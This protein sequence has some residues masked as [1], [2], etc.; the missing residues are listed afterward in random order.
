MLIITTPDNQPDDFRL[1]A[2]NMSTY[3]ICGHSD[4]EGYETVD[5]I[6]RGFMQLVL[7][8]QHGQYLT[9]E[10]INNS[11]LLENGELKRL[12]QRNAELEQQNIDIQLALTEIY[13][14]GLANG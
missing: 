5:E 6:P 9:L 8:P 14:G 10:Q 13:E 11:L 4:A 2:Q 1:L 7:P 12:S 3:Q